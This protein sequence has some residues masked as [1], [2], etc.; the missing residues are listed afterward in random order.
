LQ[1]SERPDVI[2]TT[3]VDGRVG[4]EV[5]EITD[6][7]PH[8][9]VLDELRVEVDQR[10]AELRIVPRA[11]YWLSFDPETA[12]RNGVGAGYEPS[13]SG[14]FLPRGRDCEK[15]LDEIVRLAY[16]DAPGR[17]ERVEASEY[18]TLAHYGVRYAK[19]TLSADEPPR[20]GFVRIGGGPVA[21]DPSTLVPT[22][23]AI[24]AQ[25]REKARTYKWDGPLWLVLHITDRRGEFFETAQAV[26]EARPEIEPFQQ[27]HILYQE[28]LMT[29]HR[30]FAPGWAQH[31]ILSS[32][33]RGHRGRRYKQLE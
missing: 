3:R 10:L 30:A 1:P 33:L 17:I 19:Q 7:G 8:S 12:E 27:V 15:V 9:G 23:E 29:T 14:R 21:Y 26:A 13:D 25:K 4:V 18:P 20:Q 22:A 16:S 5:A 24:F 28:L 32:R 11:G 6:T 31:V 2:A